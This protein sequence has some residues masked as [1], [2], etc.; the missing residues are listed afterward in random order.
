MNKIASC[1][2]LGVR[3]RE[4][5]SGPSLVGRPFSEATD[6]S[7]LAKDVGTSIGL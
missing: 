3:W 2:D 4:K 7:G 1:F 6:V 5:H